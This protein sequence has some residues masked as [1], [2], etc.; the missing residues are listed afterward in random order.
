MRPAV[1]RPPSSNP[2]GS[3]GPTYRHL[4][5][6]RVDFPSSIPQKN[7]RQ[8]YSRTR[9][10]EYSWPSK[11]IS[12]MGNIC[13]FA[14]RWFTYRCH[15]HRFCSSCIWS[16]CPSRLPRCTIKGES[17]RNSFARRFH[18]GSRCVGHHH[19]HAILPP[20]SFEIRSL[21]EDGITC[22]FNDVSKSCLVLKK[23]GNSHWTG[24]T[25]Q[26]V[27]RR[28]S[29]PTVIGNNEACRIGEPSAVGPAQCMKNPME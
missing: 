9:Q 15:R 21:G 29:T 18:F 28:H 24:F 11:N 19:T 14:W 6:H 12:R 23:R 10:I 7:A 4:E 27:A 3:S 2:S 8:P 25:R 1:P 26:G 20:P 5:K 17:R 22:I 16:Q 13:H